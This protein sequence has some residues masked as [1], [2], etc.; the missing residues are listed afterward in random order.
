MSEAEKIYIVQGSSGQWSDWT[1]W[2]VCAYRDE[3]LA[4]RHVE[5]ADAEVRRRIETTKD[6][7]YNYAA[8]AAYGKANP[9]PWDSDHCEEIEEDTT[10]GLSVVEIRDSLPAEEQSCDHR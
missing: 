9:N 5:Q 4:R 7:R 10:Y 3:T 2:D 1:T 8:L 6:I